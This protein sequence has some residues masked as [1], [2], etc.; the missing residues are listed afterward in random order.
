MRDPLSCILPN[1]SFFSL[2]QHCKP[3]E[4]DTEEEE[5]VNAEVGDQGLKGMSKSELVKKLAD[6]ER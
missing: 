3:V 2:K 4:E 6:M 1:A 5:E